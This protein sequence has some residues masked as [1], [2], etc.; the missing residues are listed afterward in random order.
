MCAFDVQISTVNDY[1]TSLSIVTLT[2]VCS[3]KECAH[4][5]VLHISTTAVAISG[6]EFLQKIY[7]LKGILSS[8]VSYFS[9]PFLGTATRRTI[10]VPAASPMLGAV[11][12]WSPPF[13]T[14]SSTELPIDV[15]PPGLGL[16]LVRPLLQK[17]LIR[18]DVAHHLVVELLKLLS[19]S[20]SQA[21]LSPE[22]LSTHSSCLLLEGLHFLCTRLPTLQISPQGAW[23]HV[24]ELLAHLCSVFACGLNV[25]VQGFV[26]HGLRFHVS[27]GG[28]WSSSTEPSCESQG[29][30]HCKDTAVRLRR[31]TGRGPDFTCGGT[32]TSDPWILHHW[33]LEVRATSM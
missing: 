6:R 23:P 1:S 10:L 3:C 17:L 18:F 7:K 5:T 33:G 25:E 28:T 21:A 32:S 20:P 11:G 8:P 4:E 24:H 9:N 2:S 27:R 22:K 30:F 15:R 13:P 29:V 16:Q 14:A 12:S 26:N 19:R 31:S